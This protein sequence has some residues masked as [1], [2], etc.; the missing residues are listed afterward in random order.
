MVELVLSIQ[1][2]LTFKWDQIKQ[3]LFSEKL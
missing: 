2:E 1:P 3:R